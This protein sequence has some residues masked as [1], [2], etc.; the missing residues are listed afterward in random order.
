MRQLL[1]KVYRAFKKRAGDFL[2][3]LLSPWPPSAAS[4]AYKIKFKYGET[5]LVQQMWLRQLATATDATLQQATYSF[6]G[7]DDI[8]GMLLYLFARGGFTNRVLVDVGA[9]DCINGN[10]A[11]LILF[12]DFK[13]FMIDGGSEGLE[14]GRQVYHAIGH[15][16]PPVFINAMLTSSNISGVLK[17]YGVP[18]N[19]DLLS[20]DVDSVDLFVA[21]QIKVT[22]RVV[23]VEFNNLW[24]PDESFSVPNIDGFQRE[25]S[26]FLYG[27][28]SLAAFHKIMT[29]RGYKLV[30]VDASGFNAFFVLDIADFNQVPASTIQSL[31]EQSPVWQ[32]SHKRSIGHLV[33]R[34]RWVEV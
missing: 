17:E 29:A 32:Q 33:R 19:I 13:G 24:G 20:I 2:F 1:R 7:D 30:G 16:H 9:G 11:N 8:D 5:R 4:L 6:L 34:K 15:T 14:T 25:L 12:H 10:T 26:D 21:E 28:A 23:V 27:G 31:Y 18:D 3:R 22:A